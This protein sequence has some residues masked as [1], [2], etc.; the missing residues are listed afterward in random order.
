MT[1]GGSEETEVVA[2]QTRSD[3]TILTTTTTNSFTALLDIALLDIGWTLPQCPIRVSTTGRF[4]SG[5]LVRNA[6]EAS[7]VEHSRFSESIRPP[8]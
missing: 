6:P 3:F 4:R 8:S 5:Q 2:V 7:A 1:G